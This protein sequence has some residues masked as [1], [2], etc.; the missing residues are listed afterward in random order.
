MRR[1]LMDVLAPAADVTPHERQRALVA[2]EPADAFAPGRGAHAAPRLGARLI[3]RRR[4]APPRR[5]PFARPTR[6]AGGDRGRGGAGRSCAGGSG[7]CSRPAC[8]APPRSP[9]SSGAGSANSKPSSAASRAESFPSAPATVCLRSDSA[10]RSASTGST[11]SVSRSSCSVGSWRRAAWTVRSDSRRAV[12]AI[13]PPTARGNPHAGDVL[14]QP[15]PRALHDV[16][17]VV[18]RQA[19]CLGD[20]ADAAGE[21]LDERGPCRS[22]ARR[23]RAHDVVEIGGVGGY[24]MARGA[25]PLLGANRVNEG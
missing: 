21:A 4:G 15:Q 13:H 2:G 1:Q 18:R 24:A 12:V 7:R 19:V 16:L 9:R 11:T 10:R 17:G 20:R 5:R 25:R 3:R 22:I 14:E 6:R 8:R 23:R